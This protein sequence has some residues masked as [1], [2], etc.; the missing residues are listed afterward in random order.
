LVARAEAAGAGA[1]A[2]EV[3]IADMVGK[4]PACGERGVEEGDA[5]LGAKQSKPRAKLR[6]AERIRSS[7]RIRLS[8]GFQPYKP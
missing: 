1:T 6:F 2:A 7:C 8:L 4:A 3:I 5:I